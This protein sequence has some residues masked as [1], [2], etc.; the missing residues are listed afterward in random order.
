MIKKYNNKWNSINDSH[1]TYFCT[2]RPSLRERHGIDAISEQIRQKPVSRVSVRSPNSSIC[3]RWSLL[4]PVFVGTMQTRILFWTGYEIQKRKVIQ[5]TNIVIFWNTLR[6]F[7]FF[8]VPSGNGALASKWN[9]A[10]P[11]IP[12]CFGRKM[13]SVI[14]DTVGDL[15]PKVSCWRSRK[16]VKFQCVNAMTKKWKIIGRY[17]FKYF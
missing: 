5:S 4:S 15:V 16:T 8:S 11:T 7:F 3:D 13:E 10:L 17:K 2:G 14:K 1:L 9:P 12:R 6:I